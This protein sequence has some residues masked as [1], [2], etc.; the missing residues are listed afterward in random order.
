[1]LVAFCDH[2]PDPETWFSFV[3]DDNNNNNNE[4]DEMDKLT[5][6]TKKILKFNSSK[7]YLLWVARRTE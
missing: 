3:E 2:H 4:D 5:K 6:D 1:M 7:E